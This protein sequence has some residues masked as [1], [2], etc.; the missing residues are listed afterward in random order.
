MLGEIEDEGTHPATPNNCSPPVGKVSTVSS[1][2]SDHSCR[3]LLASLHPDVQSE[4]IYGPLEDRVALWC[5]QKAEEVREEINDILEHEFQKG[6]DDDAELL[7]T[8]GVEEHMPP[9]QQSGKICFFCLIL[10]VLSTD[11]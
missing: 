3:K 9:G 8:T 7:Q 2:D 11:S 10:H 5:T 6:I 4:H 1:C